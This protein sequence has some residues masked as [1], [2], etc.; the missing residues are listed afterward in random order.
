VEQRLKI[1]VRGVVQGVGFRPFVYRL[2]RSHD[3]GGYVA[4]TDQGVTIEVQGEKARV[5]EFLDRLRTD[6]PPLAE[7][8]DVEI[9]E[10]PLNSRK[11]FSIEGSTSVGEEEALVTPD[12]ATCDDCLRELRDQDDRRYRY[13]FINCTNCGPRFTI[14]AHLP[15]DRPRTTMRA[16]RMCPACDA[17]YHDPADR[18]FHAQPNACPVCGPSLTY[19]AEDGSEVR[20]ADPLAAAVDALRAGKVIAVKGLGG[21]HLAC[22]ARRDDV[23]ARLRARKDREEKPLAI[24]VSGMEEVEALCEV[25]PEERALLVSPRRP[26]V[27]MR[28]RQGAEISDLVA[29]HQKYLGVMLPYTPLHHLLLRDSGMVLIM[30][31]G[32]RSEEPIVHTNPGALDRLTS[33]A[34]GFLLHDR[35]IETRCDD[36][37]TRVWRGKELIVRR[38]RG[39]A[40]LPIEMPVGC[41]R[42]ILACGGELKNTFCLTRGS[43]AILSHHIGD[44]KEEP[45]F[46]SFVQGIEHLRRLFHID[47]QVVTHDLHPD[48]LSTRYA[49]SLEGVRNVGVQHHHAHVASC[50]AEHG[51]D[52][53][54][55]GISFDGAG[56]GPDGTIWGGEFLIADLGGYERAGRLAH[57]SMPGGDRATE[58]PW[59]M[60]LSLLYRVFGEDLP[61]LRC[62]AVRERERRG[63]PVLA[64]M[65]DV[66]LR[67]PLTSSAGRLFDAVASLAGVR[68]YISYEGQ[69][70]IELEMAADEREPGAY[71]FGLSVEPGEDG[72]EVLVVDPEPMVHE[73]VSDL[74]AGQEASIVAARFHRGLAQITGQ[75]AQRIRDRGGP[76]TAVLT[77]GVFQNMFLCELVAGELEERGFE[78]L[79]HSR[80]PPNDG[81]I[82]LGQAAVAAVRSR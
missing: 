5:A 47:V 22:D 75:T 12:V 70:A 46:D 8:T 44:L 7:I 33:I 50:L 82:S 14:I 10:L 9:A 69:A 54:V 63:W 4:N 39:Y 61:P 3:L 40:P 67:T 66:G 29:P 58:E 43:E 37:V 1:I 64:R 31:S 53:P 35:E 51:R 81:G 26:I 18:R 52:E 15:Y 25:C 72:K 56:Y 77:G 13:P 60:A 79:V 68:D 2:A 49:L 48:Y 32:N 23:V 27:L 62:A 78:V 6:H 57:L 42:S 71:S 41:D 38:S 24:M 36:S 11:A 19:V 55:I 74:L 76:G 59:R 80:V 34:D 45:A 30:T 17:E 73:L 20:G 21:V 16:F 28:K 65:I